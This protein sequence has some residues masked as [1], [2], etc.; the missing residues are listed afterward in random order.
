MY[1]FAGVLSLIPAAYL[2]SSVDD[3][4][5]LMRLMHTGT[6]AD[7]PSVSSNVVNWHLS[8]RCVNYLHHF[9]TQSQLRWLSKQCKALVGLHAAHS[10][11][12][13]S[14]IC[15]KQLLERWLAATVISELKVLKTLTLATA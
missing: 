12:Q 6:K 15:S 9:V 1:C 10:T 8:S 4:Q 5:I 11:A 14:N 2:R 7:L 3:D 13:H